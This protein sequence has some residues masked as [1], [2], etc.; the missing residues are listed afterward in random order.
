M[1]I[2]KRT[3]KSY[4]YLFLEDIKEEIYR[5]ISKYVDINNFEPVTPDQDGRTTKSEAHHN[6]YY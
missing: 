6:I 5:F 2:I 3:I 1:E 4:H